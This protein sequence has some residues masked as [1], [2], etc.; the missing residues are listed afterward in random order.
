MRLE[1]DVFENNGAPKSACSSEC[2]L[3]QEHCSHAFR[4]A[5]KLDQYFNCFFQPP[6]FFFF[7]FFLTTLSR[8]YAPM[9]LKRK[10]SVEKKKKKRETEVIEEENT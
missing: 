9:V 2:L 7:F 8:Y 5:P 1:F 3:G 6:F 4:V 10:V